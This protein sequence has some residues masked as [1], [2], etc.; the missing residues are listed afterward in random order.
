[1]ATDWEKTGGGKRRSKPAKPLTQ[2]GLLRAAMTYL[3]RHPASVKRFRQVI[4]RKV[5][6]AHARCPGDEGVYEDWLAE[7][8]RKC[9]AYGLLDDARFAEG[10]ARTLHRRGMGLRGIRQ[11]LRQKGLCDPELQSA[12]DALSE[13]GND[14]DLVAALT[15]ARKK[16]FGPYGPPSEDPKD[17]R[18]QMASMARRGFGFGLVR[19]VL[20]SDLDTLEALLDEVR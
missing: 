5:Q 14:P 3:Q 12:L 6:R 10:V 7:T 1:M 19:R 13:G 16:R 2:A 18:R 9:R 4:R 11:R 15:F 17:Y 20:D 8:E